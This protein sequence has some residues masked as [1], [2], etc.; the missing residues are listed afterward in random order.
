MDTEGCGKY[1]VAGD[2]QKKSFPD[3]DMTLVREAWREGVC[4]FVDRARRG[5]GGATRG[6]LTPHL[7][8][9]GVRKFF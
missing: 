6:T 8:G 2:K 5:K 4:F 9:E 7:D 3:S 1:R